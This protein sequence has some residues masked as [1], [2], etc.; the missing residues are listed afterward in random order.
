M[1]LFGKLLLLFILVPL[2]ELAIF[3]QLGK[4]ISLP[5]TLG[6]IVLTGILGAVLAKQQGSLAMKNFQDALRSGKLPHEE[7]TDGILVL[8]AGA[9]LI[10]P[11][12]LTDTVGFSL[13]LPPVRKLL[14]GRIGGWLKKR[15]TVSAPMLNPEI[16]GNPSTSTPQMK[17]AKGRVVEE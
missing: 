10:T 11:G 7:A 2:V 8:I 3:I 5:V 14:R 13:L 15:I 6:I 17:E 12:F 4:A 16:Q 9:V 1:P